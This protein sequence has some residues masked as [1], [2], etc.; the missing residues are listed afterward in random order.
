MKTC[1]SPAV[2]TKWA[3]PWRGGRK[4][5]ASYSLC[6][7]LVQF[8]APRHFRLLLHLIWPRRRASRQLKPS[9]NLNDQPTARSAAGRGGAAGEEE[10]KR[11]G[12]RSGYKKHP[13]CE[14]QEC[15]GEV[16]PP[17]QITHETPKSLKVTFKGY[18]IF[19]I[20]PSVPTAS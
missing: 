19:S 7:C 20:H 3:G 1:N 8:S 18:H 13:V 6:L 16:D 4:F 9:F 12:F 11:D 5:T 15:V 2:Q 17:P 14:I 10:G